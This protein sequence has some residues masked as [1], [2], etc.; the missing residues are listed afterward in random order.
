MKKRTKKFMK[1]YISFFLRLVSVS[2]AFHGPSRSMEREAAL[3]C[4]AVCAE[5]TQPHGSLAALALAPP[6]RPRSS[7]QTPGW[8]QWVAA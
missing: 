7:H 2:L 8:C 4:H 3:G 5:Q 6:H 1:N